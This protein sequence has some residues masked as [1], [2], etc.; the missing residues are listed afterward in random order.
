LKSAPLRC[1]HHSGKHLLRLLES[2][3]CDRSKSSMPEALA[4]A[5]LLM[6]NEPSCQ[7]VWIEN[8]VRLDSGIDLFK[9]D[10]TVEPF[11][12]IRKIRGEI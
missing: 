4:C 10:H 9:L 7:Y 6:Y 5:L 1:G 3:C 12:F 2:I 11:S 8:L